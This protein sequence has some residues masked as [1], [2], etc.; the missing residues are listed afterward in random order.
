MSST[1]IYPYRFAT[2]AL[3][4]RIASLEIDGDESL[5][6][7]CIDSNHNSINLMSLPSDWQQ[8]T[9]NISVLDEEEQLDGCLPDAASLDDVDVWVVARNSR[10]RIRKSVRLERNGSAWQGGISL[11]RD[12][13]FLSTGLE[14]FA[15]LKHDIE[16]SNG[17]ANSSRERIA[18]STPWTIYTDTVPPMP[19]GAMNSAWLNFAESDR[20]ELRE[21][22]DCVWYV[23]LTDASSPKLLLNEGIPQLKP[24]LSVESKTSKGARVRD[25]LIC[26]ILQGVLGELVSFAL[27][28]SKGSDLEEI[29]DWQRKMLVS[30]ARRETRAS[31]RI[32][33]QDWLQWWGDTGQMSRVLAETTTSI[34]RHL[35]MKHST[36]QL[37]KSVEKEFEDA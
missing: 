11:G 28:T 31:E 36:T 37:A 22:A 5:G 29:P 24:A 14:S 6:R 19:G 17:Y 33:A 13:M 34:Q 18:D 35:D 32:V 12:D 26:S 7:D 20:P 23:D 15:T 1:I 16:P 25:A 21:R 4:I 8:M 2:E 3:Q 10:T 27:N 9:I 30:L